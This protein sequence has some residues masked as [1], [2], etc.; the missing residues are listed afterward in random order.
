MKIP[1]IIY[2]FGLLGLVP[3]ALALTNEEILAA[4]HRYVDPWSKGPV[5]KDMIFGTH[6]KELLTEDYY[7]KVGQDPAMKG[8]DEVLESFK[9]APDNH[10]SLIHDIKD[11]FVDPDGVGHVFLNIYYVA[12]KPDGSMC[13]HTGPV[14][15]QFTVA[16]DGRISY[17]ISHWNMMPLVECMTAETPKGEL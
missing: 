10:V 2:T 5:S 14:Y 16:E 9:Y 7:L 13:H 12:K 17:L 15:N 11:E 6:T 3:S 8:L 4:Y 1:F